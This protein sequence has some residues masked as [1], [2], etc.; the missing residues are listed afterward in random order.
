M[1]F[2]TIIF[3][4]LL[5]C[6]LHLPQVKAE[7]PRIKDVATFVGAKDNQLIGYGL[8]TGLNTTGDTD[9]VLTRQ[10]LANLVRRINIQIDQANVKAKNSAIVIVTCRIPPDAKFGQKLDVTVS[11]IADAKSLQGGTL[12]QTALYGGNGDIYA[13]AQ[14]SLSIGGF[15][16]GQGG[17]GGATFT[18]NHPTAG[19]IP[20]GA[21]VEKEIPTDL[22]YNGY[23][24]INLRERDIT[25]AVR[26]AN[27]INEQVAPLAHAASS[28]TVRVYVPPDY[29]GETKNMEFVAR[30]ENVIFR[31]DVAARIVINERTGTIVANSKI[32]IDA[33]AVAHGNLTVSII[34]TPVISQPNPFT[35]NIGDLRAGDAGDVGNSAVS[36]LPGANVPLTIGGNVV[37]QN[38]A[39]SQ[40]QAPTGQE[41][42]P[43]YTVV[44]VPSNP[45]IANPQGAQGGNVA[46]QPGAQTVLTQQTT[47]QVEEEKRPMVVFKDL[48]TVED[49]VAAFNAMG[50]TPRDMMSIFQNMK[51]AG[52]LQAEL[53]LLGN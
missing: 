13:T 43:G 2:S 30:V 53:V 51:Q 25:S 31:P 21:I 14:G 5:L 11:S 4:L 7:A 49:V 6:S 1:K 16:V 19:S 10:T 28:S 24:E 52:A 46:A 15:T 50:V 22:F 35:G 48:P 12:V 44:L 33:C 32:K 17:L 38:A 20:G 8:V 45:P 18:K 29:Q 23:L 40:I 36:T 42:P 3:A 9:P 26:M 39:G 41:P 34:S 27:A 47:I 37:Y